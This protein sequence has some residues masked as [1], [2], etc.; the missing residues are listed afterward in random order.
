LITIFS[1]PTIAPS[2]WF[3]KSEVPKVPKMTKVTK[4]LVSLR[5][6]FFKMIEFLNFRH[7]SSL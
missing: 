2:G 7:S 1:V 6:I 3:W 5:S 4:V